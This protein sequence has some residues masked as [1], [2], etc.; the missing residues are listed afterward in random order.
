MSASGET[1]CNFFNKYML[2][3]TLGEG[4]ACPDHKR[5]KCKT[6]VYGNALFKV[7]DSNS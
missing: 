2:R 1:V 7:S 4:T 3:W 6:S 5:K